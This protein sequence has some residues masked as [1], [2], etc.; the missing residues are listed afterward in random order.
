M[1]K[2]PAESL[3]IV[4]VVAISDTHCLHE[5]R[6]WCHG[7]LGMSNGFWGIHRRCARLQLPSGDVLVHGGDLSYEESRSMDALSFAARRD[8]G[9]ELLEWLKG[10]DLE[11]GS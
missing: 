6:G 4:R 2:V 7:G 9:E 8:S 1:V 10:S 11:A 3:K 5:R